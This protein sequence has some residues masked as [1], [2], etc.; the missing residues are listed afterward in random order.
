MPGG[1]EALNTVQALLKGAWKTPEIASLS[2][3]TEKICALN[4]WIFLW[5]ELIQVE[6]YPFLILM[7][8]VLSL[9]G[10]VGI[11]TFALGMT[12]DQYTKG[13]KT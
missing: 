2:T 12:N 13:I 5:F 11:S 1:E 8:A 3:W 10:L 6:C 7:S 4:F 9:P